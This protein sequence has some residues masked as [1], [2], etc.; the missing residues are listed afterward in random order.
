M[1]QCQGIA[2][3][4]NLFYRDRECNSCYFLKILQKNG[5][6]LTLGN[7]IYGP[8]NCAYFVVMSVQK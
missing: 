1:S 3:L 5:K 8:L 4:Q 2:K 6:L 7:R